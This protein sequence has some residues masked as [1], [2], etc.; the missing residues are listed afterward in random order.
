MVVVHGRTAEGGAMSI[1]GFRKTQ[2]V[3]PEEALAGRDTPMPV[4]IGI[5]MIT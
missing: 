5:L 2:M 4:S 3:K 1:F